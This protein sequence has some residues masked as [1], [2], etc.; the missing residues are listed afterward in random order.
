[1]TINF[2][3]CRTFCAVIL[4]SCGLEDAG[5]EELE[6]SAAVHGS[7]DD[8]DAVE[9]ALGGTC[10]PRCQSVIQAGAIPLRPGTPHPG[11]RPE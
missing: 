8:L 7:L 5:P 9:L 4:L 3:F 6:A 11:Q 1:V 2:G 10:G